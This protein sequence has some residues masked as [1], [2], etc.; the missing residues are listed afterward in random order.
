MGGLKD[1]RQV[2]VTYASLTQA[3]KATPMNFGKLI[4]GS[5]DKPAITHD[6]LSQ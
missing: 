1:A 2:K 3:R 6:A 4:V 5:P